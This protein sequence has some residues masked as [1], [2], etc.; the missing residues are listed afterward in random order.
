MVEDFQY[1]FTHPVEPE[2]KRGLGE[3]GRHDVVRD[4]EEQPVVVTVE[5]GHY[6]A[7]SVLYDVRR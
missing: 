6:P 1:R 5:F 3:P 7:L 2:A 4:E